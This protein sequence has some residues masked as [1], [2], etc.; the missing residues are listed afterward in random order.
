MLLLSI[1]HLENEF[2]HRGNN[3]AICRFSSELAATCEFASNN[4][5]MLRDQLME[6]VNRHC[7]RERLLL[8]TDLTLFFSLI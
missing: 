1:M 6:N 7:V 3:P 8:E 4:D 5:E 2:K